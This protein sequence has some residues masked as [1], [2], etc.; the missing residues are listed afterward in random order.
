MSH[1][2]S[3]ADLTPAD[4][5]LKAFLESQNYYNVRFLEDGVVCNA[6]FIFTTAVIINPNYGGFERRICYPKGSGLAERMITDMKSVDDPP[7]PGY[8]ALK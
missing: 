4:I 2:K 6:H 7:L 1:A 5:K 8:T 3:F